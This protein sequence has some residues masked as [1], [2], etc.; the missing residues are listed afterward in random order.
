MAFRVI[1]AVV[2][3][4][5]LAIHV[6]PPVLPVSAT[7]GG[8]V[9]L[10]AS[11]SPVGLVRDLEALR[12][13]PPFTEALDT[14]VRQWRFGPVEPGEGPPERQVL[15]IGVFRP[16]ALYDLAPPAPLVSMAAVPATVPVPVRWEPTA[17]PR[18]QASRD[19][20]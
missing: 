6:V 9:L 11:L 5:G 18:R 14:A 16:A 10:K 3:A 12:H 2:A 15:I 13:V 8:E 20:R 19:R 4:A 7:G 1:A 17:P